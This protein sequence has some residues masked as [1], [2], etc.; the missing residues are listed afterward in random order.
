MKN[1]NEIKTDLKKYSIPLQNILLHVGTPSILVNDLLS[2]QFLFKRGKFPFWNLSIILQQWLNILIFAKRWKRGVSS[3]KFL[4]ASVHDDNHISSLI[5]NFAL[6]TNN[7]YAV[8]KWFPGT[9]IGLSK[10]NEIFAPTPIQR[11]QEKAW[12]KKSSTNIR[13][14]WDVLVSLNIEQDTSAWKE[15][16]SY[17]ALTVLIASSTNNPRTGVFLLPGNTNFINCLLFYFKFLNKIFHNQQFKFFFNTTKLIN[18]KKTKNVKYTKAL[19][20]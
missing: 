3:W 15:L 11:K 12:A 9:L 18:N 10:L 1:M 17:D 8:N 2:D 19:S 7:Y 16:T 14:H 4:Y 6:S 13:G 20:K 5:K